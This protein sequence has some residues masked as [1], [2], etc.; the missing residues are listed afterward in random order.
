MRQVFFFVA[1]AMF[2]A[3]SLSWASPGATERYNT[4]PDHVLLPAQPSYLERPEISVVVGLKDTCESI[5][6][7]DQEVRGHK[8]IFTIRMQNR[9]DQICL[10][11]SQT[12]VT[13]NLAIERF[14]VDSSQRVDIYF[15][16]DEEILKY[17]GSIE[18]KG[19]KE[20]MISQHH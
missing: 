7:I 12:N 10:Q 3:F 13:V 8:V 14:R 15:R 6:S 4:L 11:E 1:I 18:F 2:V 16:E 5:E 9:S 20:K 17:F 19:N